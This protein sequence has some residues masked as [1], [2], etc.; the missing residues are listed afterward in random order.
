MAIAV[1]LAILIPY[2]GAGP[3]GV[4]GTRYGRYEGDTFVEPNGGSVLAKLALTGHRRPEPPAGM[5]T[6]SR[7]TPLCSAWVFSTEF[8]G[9]DLANADP[10]DTDGDGISGRAHVFIDGRVGRFGW[11][12]QIP[13]LVE[14][15]RDAVSV[16]FG[17]TVPMLVLLDDGGRDITPEYTFGRSS[18][19]DDIADP[20]IGAVTLET[21]T[22]YIS[23]LAPPRPKSEVENGRR[24]FEF[25]G[26][27][28]CHI[29]TLT[30]MEGEVAAYTDLL[31]HEILPDD[32]FAVPDG[33]AR[34]REYPD[35]TTVGFVTHRIP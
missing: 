29:P 14:F 18:D 13:S 4:N 1:A 30:G 35:A 6:E 5:L 11:K 34:P 28:D 2:R 24:L 16:E 26:C 8:H 12:A 10:M 25:I 9:S 32:R 15:V 20:E 17:V 7:Q 23:Q 31:L 3:L 21:L 22:F 19:D 33:E 27:A